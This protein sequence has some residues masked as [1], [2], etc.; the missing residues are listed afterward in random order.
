M[1]FKLNPSEVREDVA[2][3]GYSDTVVSQQ[4]TDMQ[5]E[6]LN[7]DRRTDTKE[8]GGGKSKSSQK[9]KIKRTFQEVS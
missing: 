3:H 1:K 9:K 5:P 7:E 8:G 2:D 6:E 4:T